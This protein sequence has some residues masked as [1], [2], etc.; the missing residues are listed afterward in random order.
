MK[1][2]VEAVCSWRKGDTIEV[3]DEGGGSVDHLLFRIVN[4]VAAASEADGKTRTTVLLDRG[5]VR[6]IF[7]YLGVWLHKQHD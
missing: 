1:S 4:A 2:M 6:M 5:D 3:H 7:N